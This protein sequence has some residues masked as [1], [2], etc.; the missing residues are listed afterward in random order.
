L[1]AQ[2]GTHRAI[3]G[4]INEQAWKDYPQSFAVAL[5][6]IRRVLARQGW[7]GRNLAFLSSLLEFVQLTILPFYI[8]QEWFRVE[9]LSCHSSGEVIRSK[10]SAPTMNLLSE[11]TL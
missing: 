6:E 11:P 10:H 4:N 3:L 9:A 2:W 7:E 5:L 8:G 1:D